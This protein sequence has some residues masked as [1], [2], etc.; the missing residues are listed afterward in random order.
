VG[1]WAE[2]V[3]ALWS[4][5]ITIIAFAFLLWRAHLCTARDITLAS[6]GAK[7][8][9][10]CFWSSD[11]YCAINIRALTEMLFARQGIAPDSF[12]FFL[13]GK[14]SMRIFA[15]NLLTLM[16]WWWKSEKNYG[17]QRFG[18]IIFHRRNLLNLNQI[19]ESKTKMS[20][21]LIRLKLLAWSSWKLM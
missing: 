5:S 7:E 2:W 4:S 6:D 8:E 11:M 19:S 12:G 17:W 21:W 3:S 13:D 20:E 9:L 18:F 1:T 14:L 16:R 10:L 15:F